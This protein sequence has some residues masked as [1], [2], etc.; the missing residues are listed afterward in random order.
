M[1]SWVFPEPDSPTIPRHSCAPTVSETPRTAAMVPPAMRIA[2][3]EAHAIR[4]VG[5]GSTSPR[6]RRVPASN[7]SRSPSPK[8]FRQ[9][10]SSRQEHAGREQYPGRGLH[11]S[12]ALRD[13]RAET[14]A[15]LLDSE[16]EKTQEALEQNDLRDGQRRIHD[17]RSDDV[18]QHVFADDARGAG[19][20]GDRRLDVFLAPDA[21]GLPAHDSRERQ[22]A[23]GADRHE[24][25]VLVPAE[26]HRQENHEENQRQSARESR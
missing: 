9:T 2:D 17:H 18:R 1:K 7:A 24:Q 3:S 13:Q 19:A 20:R 12:G 22:P 5:R 23:D 4:S 11:L 15:R 16:P 26:H 21:Q 10:S 25:Q 8:M 14:R 6:H